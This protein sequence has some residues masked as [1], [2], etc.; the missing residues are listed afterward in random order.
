MSASEPL[1]RF[2]LVGCGRAG[3]TLAWALKERGFRLEAVLCSSPV[4]TQEAVAFLKAGQPASSLEALARSA[5]LVILALP[6]RMLAPVAQDLAGAASPAVFLHLAGA[7]S[8]AVLGP[9]AAAG[10]STG[11]CHPLTSLNRRS[12]DASAFEGVS[13]AVDGDPEA[14]AL[15]IR[16]AKAVGGRPFEARPEGR[17]LYHAGA[18]LASNA[19]VA[20]VDQAA[21]L[22]AE[23]GLTRER[24]LEALMPLVQATLRHVAQ[25]GVEAALT[26][27][28]RR[29]D[30]ETVRRHLASLPAGPPRETYLTLAR[31]TLELARRSGLPEERAAALEALLAQSS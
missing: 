1:G 10:A 15:A 5:P 21:G 3:G 8:G 20:L 27:P 16:L 28:V 4:K 2:A 29:G 24:A 9:L 22:V 23:A 6:D 12:A 14:R 18:S 17:V 11:S 31:L 25:D 30:A 19:L 13:F 26:G 7:L